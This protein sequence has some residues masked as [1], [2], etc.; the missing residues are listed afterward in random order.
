MLGESIKEVLGSMFETLLKL[1]WMWPRIKARNRDLLSEPE[2]VYKNH[3]QPNKIQQLQRGLITL[4]STKLLELNIFR[5]QSIEKCKLKWRFF[6][7]LGHKGTEVMLQY[8][9]EY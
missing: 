3:V 2:A 4:E 5:R 7:K 8:L 1:F 6:T 9:E